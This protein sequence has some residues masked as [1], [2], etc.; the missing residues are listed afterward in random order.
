MLPPTS[1]KL[2]YRSQM[3]QQQQQNQFQT[4]AEVT[5]LL[6]ASVSRRDH[7]GPYET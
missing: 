3:Q 1:A 4:T 2:H 5:K 6:Q 7:Y